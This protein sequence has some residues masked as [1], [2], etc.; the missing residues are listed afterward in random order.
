MKV[1]STPVLTPASATASAPPTPAAADN[2]DVL[3]EDLDSPV[4]LPRRADEDEEIDPLLA[5]FGTD[6][7]LP[8][9]QAQDEDGRSDGKRQDEQSRDEC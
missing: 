7:G 6:D 1:V 9:K 5:S 4:R 2:V 3:L 8:A